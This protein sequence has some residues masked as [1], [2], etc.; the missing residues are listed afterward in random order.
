M[1]ELIFT[2]P[3]EVQSFGDFKVQKNIMFQIQVEEK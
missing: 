2:R 1:I 3:I